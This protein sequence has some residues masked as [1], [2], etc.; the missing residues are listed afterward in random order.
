MVDLSGLGA[1][2]LVPT[3]F[4]LLVRG[5]P[6]R[7]QIVVRN[8]ETK[9]KGLVS[10]AA[11]GSPSTCHPIALGFEFRLWLLVGKGYNGFLVRRERSKE[12]LSFYTWFVSWQVFSP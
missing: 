4:S 12:G 3:P 10:K 6:A 9:R 1:D 7:P 11:A 2:A 5:P 8:R